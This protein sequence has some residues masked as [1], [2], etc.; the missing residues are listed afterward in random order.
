MVQVRLESLTY[1]ASGI[2]LDHPHPERLITNDG[3]GR[4]SGD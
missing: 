1:I 4:V 2:L 3:S